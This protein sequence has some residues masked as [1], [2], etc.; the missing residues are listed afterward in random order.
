MPDAPAPSLTSRILGR[1][2]GRWYFGK[3]KP[4]AAR[5]LPVA[6]RGP[7]AAPLP[8]VAGDPPTGSR[9]WTFPPLPVQS[10]NLASVAYDYDTQRLEVAFKNGSVYHYAG[11]PVALY[12]GLMGSASKGQ[13]LHRNVKTPA[14]RYPFTRVV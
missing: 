9:A 5:A 8:V 10:S 7:G 6:F 14:G 2:F 3:P 11:V 12:Q 4:S 13:Y 1:I